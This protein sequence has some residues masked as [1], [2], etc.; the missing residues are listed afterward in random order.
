MRRY[1]FSGHLSPW[2][3]SI[4]RAM[5]GL[6]GDVYLAH[7][8]DDYVM[9]LQRQHDR[10]LAQANARA[11]SSAEKAFQFE[12]KLRQLR[13]RKRTAQRTAAL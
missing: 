2:P 10:A 4:Q 8:V 5:C 6:S 9:L 3:D 11:A 12:K 13:A 1:R 7:E